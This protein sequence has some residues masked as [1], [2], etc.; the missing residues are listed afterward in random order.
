MHGLSE[1]SEASSSQVNDRRTYSPLFRRGKSHLLLLS[2]CQTSTSTI[3]TR[4]EATKLLN[5]AI[6]THSD[7]PPKGTLVHPICL[8][9]KN[10]LQHR[11]LMKTNDRRGLSSRLPDWQ[12]FSSFLRPIVL[13]EIP[14]RNKLEKLLWALTY[15]NVP[16]SILK[17]KRRR[18]KR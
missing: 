1:L 7:G 13:T 3:V 5:S 6:E 14:P 2:T 8:Q 18:R 10:K 16:A 4:T 17:Q 12:S 15:G 11:R 9:L